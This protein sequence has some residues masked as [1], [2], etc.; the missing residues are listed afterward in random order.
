MKEK[1][2]PYKESQANSITPDKN[3]EKREEDKKSVQFTRMAREVFNDCV[4][5][6]E[7]QEEQPFKM[8]F[9]L[10]NFDHHIVKGCVVSLDGVEA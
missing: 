6:H 7:P 5:R 9:S 10:Q 8:H 4:G 3:L 1:D 2:A